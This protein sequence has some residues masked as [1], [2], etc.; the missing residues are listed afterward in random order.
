M[1]RS[2]TRT[3]SAYERCAASSQAIN[4]TAGVVCRD[5]SAWFT[6]EVPPEHEL[7]AVLRF[8]HADGDLELR[9]FADD[10]LGEAVAESVTATDQERVGLVLP[11]E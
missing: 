10:D 6:L 4:F 7:T 3:V 5:G 1:V 11:M 8:R 2:K 9:L